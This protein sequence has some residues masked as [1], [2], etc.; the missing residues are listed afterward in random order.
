MKKII[1]LYLTRAS[2]WTLITHLSG[3]GDE[4]MYLGKGREGI[5]SLVELSRHLGF[6][7]ALGRTLGDRG[8]LDLVPG[9]RVYF[10]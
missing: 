2:T 5:L 10:S 3:A 7:A 1:G 9:E 4:L 6:Q 8:L